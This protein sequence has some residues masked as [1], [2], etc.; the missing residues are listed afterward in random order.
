MAHQD[1][2]KINTWYT[3]STYN[4]DE[5]YENSPFATDPRTF[6]MRASTAT[7]MSYSHPFA[8]IPLPSQHQLHTIEEMRNESAEPCPPAIRRF[9]EISVSKSEEQELVEKSLKSISLIRSRLLQ[10]QEANRKKTCE[11]QQIR[12]SLDLVRSLVH[13]I[14]DDASNKT[15]IEFSTEDFKISPHARHFTLLKIEK[16]STTHSKVDLPNAADNFDSKAPVQFHAGSGNVVINAVKLDS[17]AQS[18]KAMSTTTNVPTTPT[19]VAQAAILGV[20]NIYRQ[21]SEEDLILV[22]D[23]LLIENSSSRDRKNK[24]E[25]MTQR[26][27]YKT[28]LKQFSHDNY[29]Y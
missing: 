12:S 16:E 18:F 17:S 6:P 5:S 19:K 25:Q 11:F 13:L 23:P 20:R 8:M 24:T 27:Y 14:H 10:Q 7:S 4:A 1:R 21:Q 3:D 29:R 28:Q 22:S 15:F 9:A 26:N 2:Q